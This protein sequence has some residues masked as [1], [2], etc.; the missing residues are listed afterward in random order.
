MVFGDLSYEQRWLKVLG[1]V[2]IIILFI[3]ISYQ[4]KGVCIAFRDI[5][6]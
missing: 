6:R 2:E 5:G 4:R 1:P 3:L